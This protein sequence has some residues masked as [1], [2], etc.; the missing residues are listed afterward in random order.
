VKGKKRNK[1]RK[2]AELPH[3]FPGAIAVAAGKP[4]NDVVLAF[5]YDMGF[6]YD[7]DR[8]SWLPPT[9]MPTLHPEGGLL[10]RAKYD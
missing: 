4:V 2:V 1:K 10:R 7:P 5:M 8:H 6:L 3:T 9:S